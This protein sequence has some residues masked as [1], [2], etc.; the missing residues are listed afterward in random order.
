M[1]LYQVTPGPD[2]F[3]HLP[4]AWLAIAGLLLAL[5]VGAV[6]AGRETAQVLYPSHLRFDSLAFGVLLAHSSI[7][8]QQCCTRSSRNGGRQ[9]CCWR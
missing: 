8:D 2:R 9:Q 1:I 5:R 4:T 6:F 3:R 7:I